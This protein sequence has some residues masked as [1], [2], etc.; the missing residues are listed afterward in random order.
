MC[1]VGTAAL[2]VGLMGTA[3][4]GYS[5]YQQGQAQKAQAEYQADV[6]QV[7]ADISNMQARESI[8][9]GE[10]E[11]KQ[12]RQQVIQMQGQQVA[13]YGSSGV[14]LESGS[15]LAVLTDSAGQAEMDAQIIRSNAKKEAWGHR[16][17]AQNSMAQA[18][19]SSMQARNASTTG[20]LSAGASLMSGA[21]SVSNKW[22][23]AKKEK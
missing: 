3:V 15:P 19:L 8:R 23:S 1:D 17:G 14:Q 12:F 21:S 10:I 18:G 5:T 16:V 13:G 7:N 4:G 6:A 2:V 22:Y 9:Q 11:E 20:V